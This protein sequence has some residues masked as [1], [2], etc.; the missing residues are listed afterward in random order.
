MSILTATEK[1]YL[2]ESIAD[3]LSEYDYD[4]SDYAISRIIDTWAREKSPLIRA[5]KKHPNY[6]EGKFMIAFDHNYDR[7]VD[8]QA[9]REFS[10]WLADINGPMHNLRSQLPEEVQQKRIE[11][12]CA[13]LPDAIFSFLTNLER[14]ASRTI[15][16]ETALRINNFA[17]AVHAH[18]GQKTSRV[19]NKLLTYLGY[20]KHP[21][22]NREFAKYADSLSPLTIKRHTVLS[23]NPL[24]YLTMSFGN[25]WA[26]CHTIDKTNKRGM[27]NSYSG[28]YSS[29]TVSYMLDPSSMVLYTVD[30]E[31]N[32]DEYWSQPKINRQMYHW[33]EEKL[34][35]SRLYPQDNDCCDEVYAPYRNIVQEIISTIFEFPNLW[36]LSRGT[37]AASRYI[38]THGTHYC[39]YSNFG[40][41][42]LSRIKGSENENEFRVGAAP[43]CVECGCTHN[44]AENINCCI[45]K[46]YECED[47][48]CR[49]DEDD[50]IWVNGYP[51]C[52]DCVEYCEWCDSYHRGDSTRVQ[53][54]YGR[55]I[56]VCSCCLDDNFRYCDCCEEY[57][58][59]E[60]ITN[61]EGGYDVCN[62]CL[63]DHYFCCNECGGYYP[64]AERIIVGNS[65]YC[66]ACY[67]EIAD[68]DSEEET[69]S[70]AC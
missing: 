11:E 40:T 32:G 62:D 58:H 50:V 23:I 3:L 42:T 25:S 33:G 36:S 69:E 29:G 31:Y 55:E 45:G 53:D 14:I 61:T 70:E 64:L 52:H 38:E 51:Y 18:N 65:E 41:C 10:A 5:F 68:E 6:L 19:V 54:S 57:H 2:M 26:S 9:S 24:D 63:D 13:Y 34:V 56:D 39:D 35:Q 4:Y 15:S 47:C 8:I 66:E 59:E 30:A 43:I 67:K 1:T 49:V 21:D 37:S 20:N 28:C 48:G 7:K 60:N 27:P 12:C 46:G 16:E 22:Y 44:N 17:P